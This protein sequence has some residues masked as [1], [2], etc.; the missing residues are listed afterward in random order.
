VKR[1]ATRE[2]AKTRF[3]QGDVTTFVPEEKFDVIVFNEVLYY[4]E[5]PLETVRRYT[6]FL[7][8]G[9]IFV[10][11]NVVSRRSYAAR[12]ALAAAFEPLAWSRVSNAD[13][14]SW[15]VQVI[16]GA[17]RRPADTVGNQHDRPTTIGSIGFPRTTR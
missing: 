14:V 6:P 1:A 11:S 17:V 2:D 9:G 8:D 5:R 12:K 15:E 3:R 10:A 7:S 16:S 13:D 4:L